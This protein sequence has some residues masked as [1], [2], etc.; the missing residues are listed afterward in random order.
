MCR[1]H[2]ANANAFIVD[3]RANTTLSIAPSSDAAGV[4]SLTL[5]LVQDATGSRTVTWPSSVDWGTT[6]APTL[7]TTLPRAWP[8]S[9][10]RIASGI[11]PNA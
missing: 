5:V 3:L 1:V 8:A 11:S 4:V 10:Y 2:P 6:G 7:T 9:T